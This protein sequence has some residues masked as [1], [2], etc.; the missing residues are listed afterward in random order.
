MLSLEDKTG[1]EVEWCMDIIVIDEAA[2]RSNE[3]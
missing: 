3:L 1:D 2:E